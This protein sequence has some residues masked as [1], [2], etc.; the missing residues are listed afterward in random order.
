[1]GAYRTKDNGF[2]VDSTASPLVDGQPTPVKNG[3]ELADVL[4]ESPGVHQCYAKHWVEYAFGRKEVPQD[5][6][7]VAD[8]GARSRAGD[9]LKDVLVALVTS[10]SYL[11]RSPEVSK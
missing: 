2:D 6:K 7:L 9:S 3:V 1:M 11:N 10:K 8:L 4:A 5:D